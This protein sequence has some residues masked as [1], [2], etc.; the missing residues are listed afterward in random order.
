MIY[1]LKYLFI[2]SGLVVLLSSSAA[3]S[4]TIEAIYP[5]DKGNK[6]SV[7]VEEVPCIMEEK[8]WRYASALMQI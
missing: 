6:Y 8:G 3:Y 1:T 5:C 4:H 2:L 7:E